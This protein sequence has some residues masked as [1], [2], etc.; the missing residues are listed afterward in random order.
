MGGLAQKV[1]EIEKKARTQRK[2]AKKASGRTASQSV[3]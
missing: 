3:D 2:G 1:I